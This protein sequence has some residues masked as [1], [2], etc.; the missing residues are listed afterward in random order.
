MEE[1]QKNFNK[2]SVRLLL[3]AAREAYNNEQNRISV[4]DTKTNISLP[5]ISAYV[6][7][8]VQI[9]DYRSIFEFSTNCFSEWI[10]PASLF[11]LYTVALI[12]GSIAVFNMAKVI[13]PSEYQ[14]L[15]PSDLYDDDFLKSDEMNITVELIRLYISASEINKKRNDTR[16]KSYM[17]GWKFVSFSVIAFVVYSIL[18]NVIGR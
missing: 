14:S 1:N 8:V 6:L 15:K 7:A 12:M 18:Y 11:A 17:R 13:Y 16:I 10:I 5:I 4:I 3:E 2:D 9:V